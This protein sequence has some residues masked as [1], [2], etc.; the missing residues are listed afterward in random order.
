MLMR[1]TS[2]PAANRAARV[3]RS[4]EAGPRVAM[5]LTRRRRACTGVPPIIGGAAAAA[6]CS[7]RPNGRPRVAD[8]RVRLVGQLHRPALRVLAGVDL[9]EAGAVIA[10]DIAILPALDLELAV[11]GAHEHLA[12]P[13][14]AALVHR[15]EII[16]LGRQRAA[17]KRHAVERLQVPPALAD[18]S[19]AVGIAERDADPVVAVVAHAQV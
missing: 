8:L 3:S 10:A 1:K 6:R 12:L 17:H 15:V 7:R 9:E 16:I 19:L 18:P 5:I 13:L 11:R 2:A 14:A 4:R